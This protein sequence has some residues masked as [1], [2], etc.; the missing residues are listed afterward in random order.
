MKTGVREDEKAVFINAGMMKELEAKSRRVKIGGEPLC[1]RLLA[2]LDLTT[3]GTSRRQLR[4]SL[5]RT[6]G[7]RRRSRMKVSIRAIWHAY[8]LRFKIPI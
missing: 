6:H 7:W 1:M 3:V 2:C 4:Q 8:Y 5:S